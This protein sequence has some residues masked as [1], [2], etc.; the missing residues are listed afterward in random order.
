MTAFRA[1]PWLE[2]FSTREIEV[3]RLISKG[4]SN[5]EIAQKL[6]LSVETVKWYNKQMY[7]KLGAK[8]RI[9]ALNKAVELDLLNLEEGAFT[10]EKTAIAGNL[11]AQLTSFV[12]RDKDVDEIKELLRKN[13]L[14]VLTGPGGSGKTRLALKVGRELNDRYNDGVWLVELANIHDPSLVLGSIVN[15][16]NLTERA[17]A[18]LE[19]VLKRFLSRR[20]LLLLIDN[21]EHLLECVPLI[22]ELLA[23][24]PQLSVLG[25][26]RERLHIYGEQ[27]YPVQPLNLPDRISKNSI[28][29]VSKIDAIALFIRRAHAVHPT[30]SLNNTALEDIA[31]IC[32]RLD[33]LPLAIELCAPM[34]KVFSLGTIVGRIEE[35]LDAIPSGPRDLPARQQTLRDTIQWSHDLLAENE[36]RLFERLAIFNGGGTLQAVEAICGEG[37]SG[38]IRN[39]LFALVNKNL[40]LA[41]ERRDGEIHFGMLETIRQ[42]GREKLLASG[43]TEKL[44]KR[45]ARYFVELSKQGSVALRGPDQLIWINRFIAMHDNLRAALEWVTETGEVEG[46]LHFVNDIYE[47]WLRHSDYEEGLQQYSRL[48]ALADARQYPETYL[49][50]FNHLTRIYW[51]LS[52]LEEARTLAEQALL[53]SKSQTNKLN[54]VVALLNLGVILISDGQPNQAENYLKEAKGM[55]Q[56]YHYEWELARAHMLLGN[57]Y[58]NQNRYASARFHLSEAFNL[59]KK[60]GDIFFQC[61]VQW[62][63]GNLEIKQGNLN[64][65]IIEYCESLRIARAVENRWTIANIIWGLAD[66]A[67]A[68]GLH[69]R[70]LRLYLASKK[71][72]EDVGAWGSGD[73][74]LLKDALETA[75]VEL[76]EAEVQSAL[77]DVE[78]MTMEQ[79][80]D[81]ALS[82]N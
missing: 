68:K 36:K 8:N 57:A 25:T 42:Y 75:R 7:M 2:S 72:F 66:V 82:D 27:E 63:G 47:F 16:L 80:I 15:V 71:I 20:H 81:F 43:K 4:A 37:I 19:E 58:R 31:R 46:A 21:L 48:L 59:Y 51:L 12:G 34:V 18:P 76:G 3:L 24:A 53:L 65:A 50:A 33:G 40:V 9:Q 13:R 64:E 1:Q 70:A 62:I 39:T 38:N 35:N 5:R 26:S 54:T 29:D 49:E 22:G 6:H 74:D 10:Q 73:D 32:I 41:Q 67:K 44:A 77:E 52:R 56:E 78:H 11:P 30:L 45:H 61:T 23:T 17:N 55:C 28:E 69:E 60:L 14:V 79:A